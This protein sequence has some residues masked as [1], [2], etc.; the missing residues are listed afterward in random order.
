[1][2]FIVVNAKVVSDNTGAARVIPVLLTPSGPLLPLIDYCLTESG[3]RAWMEKLVRAVKLFLEYVEVNA[4]HGEEEWRLFRNFSNA[5]IFGTIDKKTM[6]DSSGLYWEPF[7]GNGANYFITLLTEFFDWMGKNEGPRALKF[8]PQYGG[9]K[10]NLLLDE[11][12]HRF[13]RSKAFLGHT[14]RDN[15]KVG[16]ITRGNR[17]PKVFPERPPEFPADRFEELLFKGFYKAG[18]HDYR[19]MLI[20]LLLYGAGFRISEPFH[21]YTSD[22][23]PHWEDSSIAFVAIHHPS[24]GIAPNNWKNAGGQRGT[25]EQYLASVFGLST[26]TDMG[27]PCHAGWKHPALDAKW[28]MQA[29]WFPPELYGRWFMQLWIRYMEQVAS[30]ERHHPFAFINLE[31]KSAGGI[32]TIKSYN[33]ALEAA[34]ERVGLEFGKT[35]GTSAH[36]PRHA[37]GQRARRNG[38]HEVIIQ[39]MMHH[40]SPGSQK[41]YTQPELKEVTDALAIAAQNLRAT[42]GSKPTIHLLHEFHPL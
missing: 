38:V 41:V 23:Q 14:W 34:V 36:G 29:H 4:I 28:Y 37:Y 27:R 32:Y 8:N 5:L 33:K 16:R 7:K 11:Q 39:R 31:S 42:Q 24:L 26:R 9:R 20:T 22:V 18:R 19:G 2:P 25:R 12:A 17:T 10:Y 40:C 6:L 1:M 35:F 15:P 21:L 13:R 3:S 30:V